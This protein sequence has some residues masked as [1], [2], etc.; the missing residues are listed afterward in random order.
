MAGCDQ[1]RPMSFPFCIINAKAHTSDSHLKQCDIFVKLLA[2][3]SSYKRPATVNRIQIQWDSC[4]SNLKKKP[5]FHDWVQKE[6]M[7]VRHPHRQTQSVCVCLKSSSL[8]K[9]WYCKLETCI[10]VMGSGI[11]NGKGKCFYLPLKLWKY[12]IHIWTG[13]YRF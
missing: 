1:R 4:I 6:K 11:P 7:K 12:I 9:D 2:V 5:N 13:T 3:L 10:I 8:V